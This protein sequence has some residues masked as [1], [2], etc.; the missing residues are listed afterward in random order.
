MRNCL[1]ILAIVGPALA[2]ICHLHPAH[3]QQA[4]NWPALR[5]ASGSGRAAQDYARVGLPASEDQP[6]SEGPDVPAWIKQAVKDHYARQFMMPDVVIWKF[7]YTQPYPTGGTAICGRVNYTN[8][9]HRYVGFQRFYALI[10]YHR[11]IESA[12]VSVSLMEDPVH[13][14]ADAYAIACGRR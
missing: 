2:G 5:A 7:D 3:A 14:S 10:K 1:P 13:A 9:I 4:A 12:I 8:S 6:A 11:L